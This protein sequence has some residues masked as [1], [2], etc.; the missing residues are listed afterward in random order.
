VDTFLLLDGIE[1]SQ[2][3]EIVGPSTSGKTQMCLSACLSV[4]TSQ[5]LATALYIDTQ[6][7]FSEQRFA[8]MYDA[9][10]QASGEEMVSLVESLNRIRV[11]EVFEAT[12]LLRLLVNVAK[13][14]QSDVCSRFKLTNRLDDSILWFITFDCYRFD[15][16]IV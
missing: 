7:S 6:S 13:E 4:V 14:I 16:V 12:D 5:T 8:K 10:K 2:I 1:S 9:K 11:A 3:T 15:R